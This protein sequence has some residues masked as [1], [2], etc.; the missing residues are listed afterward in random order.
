M[1]KRVFAAAALALVGALPCAAQDDAPGGND[2]PMF[3]PMPGY[4]LDDY[5]AADVGDL[6]VYLEP[7]RHVEGHGL[8]DTRPIADNGTDHGRAQNRRV[9]LVK[10]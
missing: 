10:K 1:S 9:E 7:E 4:Y 8:G 2:H 6:D 5:G 3:T